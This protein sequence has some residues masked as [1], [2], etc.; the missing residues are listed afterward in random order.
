[1]CFLE[2]GVRHRSQRRR[3]PTKCLRSE[4]P[5]THL[6]SRTFS[7]QTAK[8]TSNKL[9]CLHAERAFTLGLTGQREPQ[10]T[11][12]LAFQTSSEKIACL[13]FVYH[14]FSPGPA[15][16]FLFHILLSLYLFKIN[17]SVLNLIFLM[18]CLKTSSYF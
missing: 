11:P 10:Y 1:M 17:F 4:S 15:S 16:H 2:S 3:T 9:H 13:H 6:P 18:S 12:S 7:N 14:S 8:H 5:T